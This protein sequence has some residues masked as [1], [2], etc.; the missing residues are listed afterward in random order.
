MGVLRTQRR[1]KLL[2]K[3]YELSSDE[4]RDDQKPYTLSILGDSR[5]CT[6]YKTTH[7]SYDPTYA[8]RY[9]V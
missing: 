9:R 4:L 3:R 2:H 7:Y 1:G 6:K 5:T 8:G